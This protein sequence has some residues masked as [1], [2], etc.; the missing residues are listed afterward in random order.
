M[1]N[2]LW[3]V[4]MCA[5]THVCGIFNHLLGDGVY[6]GL[7]GYQTNHVAVVIGRLSQSQVPVDLLIKGL[8]MGYY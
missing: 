6:V 2:H 5:L 4:S 7:Q 1:D 3:G 8:N